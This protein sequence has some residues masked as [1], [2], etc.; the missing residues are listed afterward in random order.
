MVSIWVRRIRL[1][2]RIFMRIDWL[3]NG[4]NRSSLLAVRTNATETA[5]SE[6]LW[7]VR[8]WAPRAHVGLEWKK[9]RHCTVAVRWEFLEMIA[10]LLLS[11]TEERVKHLQGE[12]WDYKG[13]YYE[14]VSATWIDY[15]RFL[16]ERYKNEYGLFDFFIPFWPSS[17]LSEAHGHY[18]F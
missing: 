12:R 5:L 16:A 15:S 17:V 4:R 7:N 10:Y 13:W 3:S 11:R 6:I 8:C 9:R 14:P 18:C 2:S 1:L